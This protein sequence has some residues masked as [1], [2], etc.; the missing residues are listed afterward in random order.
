MMIL[1]RIAALLLI[2]ASA[3]ALA[4]GGFEYTKDSKDLKLGPF[5]VAVNQ[6]ETVEVPKWAGFTG[7]GIGVALL[8]VRGR[9]R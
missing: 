2:A 3:W 7:L 6:T 5:E 8:L 4:Y 9:K 1:L